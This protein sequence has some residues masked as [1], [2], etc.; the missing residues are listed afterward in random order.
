MKSTG[1]FTGK[2]KVF[3]EIEQPPQTFARFSTGSGGK[4]QK[5][6]V[7]ACGKSGLLPFSHNPSTAESPEIHKETIA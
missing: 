6:P 5:W 2:P 4:R 3:S 7:E 1:L